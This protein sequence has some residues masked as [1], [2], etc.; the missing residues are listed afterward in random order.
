[1]RR[2]SYAI[3][4]ATSIAIILLIALPLVR[5]RRHFDE[6]DRSSDD[7]PR[8]FATAVLA[9]VEPQAVILCR[10]ELCE[11]LRY[12]QFAEGQR[13]DVLLDQ[14]E[15]EAGSDWAERAT[16]YLPQHPV[17]ALQ[18]NEQ[19]AARYDLYPVSETYDLWQVLG[20]HE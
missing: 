19:L 14:T 3:A 18:F 13:L 7:V 4:A 12:L 15:P 1:M 10:W 6:L 9:Q 8:Q 17:Y 5:G 16:L 20:P 2:L 11:A